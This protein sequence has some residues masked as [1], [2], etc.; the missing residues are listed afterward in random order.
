MD[1]LII[2]FL[3][4]SLQNCQMPWSIVVT[5]PNA[6]WLH[7]LCMCI[8]VYIGFEQLGVVVV[9][10]H[11]QPR[12]VSSIPTWALPLWLWVYQSISIVL[13]YLSCKIGPAFAWGWQKRRKNISVPSTVPITWW[14]PGLTSGANGTPAGT[15][16]EFLVRLQEKCQK[17]TS[18]ICLYIVPRGSKSIWTR[19]A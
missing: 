10:S 5:P 19:G 16:D 18:S 17:R 9:V 6:H 15:V 7:P 13:A 4:A 3:Q 11:S 12:V 2:H 8:S 1:I 14:G